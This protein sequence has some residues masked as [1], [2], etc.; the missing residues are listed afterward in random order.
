M[1]AGAIRDRVK[2]LRRVP[3]S[4]LKE[5][6]RNWRDHPEAQQS[7]LAAVLER[8][9]FADVLLAREDE[10]G[11]LILVDGHLRRGTMGDAP[12][13]VVVLDITADEADELLLTLDPI[14]AMA[15]A[16]NAPAIPV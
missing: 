14:A 13:P 3:A 10:D 11:E 8:I 4:Q 2:E 16:D 12:V 5:N 7:A 15:E 9:G 1:E 6:P